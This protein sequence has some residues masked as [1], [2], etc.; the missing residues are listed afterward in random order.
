M[1]V[2]KLIFINFK[3]ST[4][5]LLLHQGADNISSVHHNPE[6]FLCKNTFEGYRLGCFL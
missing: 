4:T 1:L 3:E 6:R 2:F 5:G